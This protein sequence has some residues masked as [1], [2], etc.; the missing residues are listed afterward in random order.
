MKVDRRPLRQRSLPEPYVILAHHTAL[1]TI[2]RSSGER[3]LFCPC[4]Y[5]DLFFFFL[6]CLYSVSPLFIWSD[7]KF[8]YLNAIAIFASSM[9]AACIIPGDQFCVPSR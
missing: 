5:F 4:Y 7:D 8:N 2:Y 9:A 6:F 1:Q 3:I